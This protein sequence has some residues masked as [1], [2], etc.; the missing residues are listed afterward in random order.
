MKNTIIN[1][2]FKII[3]QRNYKNKFIPKKT[4][5]V[6]IIRDGGIGDAI[7]I[8]PL[9]RELKK[10]YPNIKIDIFA[11]LN[12]YNMYKYT[13]NVESVYVK[14]KKRQWIKTWLNLLKMRR[15]NYDVTIDNTINRFHRTLY[16]IFINPKYAF[17]TK[18]E[19]RKYDFDRS[20]LSFYYFTHDSSAI[21]H[22]VNKRLEVLKVF[23]VSVY[24]NK[25]DFYLPK[26]ENII[27]KNF[28]H[29][30]SEFTKIGLNVEGSSESRTLNRQ[31]LITISNTF[32]KFKKIKIILFYLPTNRSL[33]NE[34]IKENNLHN[35]ILSPSTKTIYDAADLLN[36]LDLLIS[37]DTSFIHIASGL[38]IPTVGI[39]WNNPIKYIEWGPLSKNNEIVK[40][41]GTESNIKN[42]NIDEVIEK[43]INLLKIT[44][45]NY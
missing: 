5:K 13:S 34:I 9:I 10:N 39:F 12:N 29:N 4:K 45:K 33:Y 42:I 23:K 6:L 24:S 15:N 17:A 30:L 11:S 26:K 21:D 2:L 1:F 37:P 18:D 28:T 43:S 16:T 44:N 36:R 19:K 3:A 8:Y 7:C 14:Y 38:D 25:M 20:N 31:Q 27:N 40:P 22:I 32:N 35:I 41:K